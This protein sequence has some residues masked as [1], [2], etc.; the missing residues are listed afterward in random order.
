MFINASTGG[1]NTEIDTGF[2]ARGGRLTALARRARQDEMAVFYV[3]AV[4]LLAAIVVPAWQAARITP[5]I[6]RQVVERQVAD[7]QAQPARAAG[8]G[9]RLRRAE[10]GPAC[11]GV[12]YGREAG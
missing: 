9:D 10:V 2:A 6:E 7:W 5:P 4:A 1:G 12:G 3:V 11:S 8:K